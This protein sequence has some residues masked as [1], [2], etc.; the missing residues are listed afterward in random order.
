MIIKYDI[1]L[2]SGILEGVTSTLFDHPRLK[3]VKKP[4]LVGAV[5]LFRYTYKKRYS[6]QL[7]CRVLC[8]TIV[9]PIYVSYLSDI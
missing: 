1:Y 9:W 7:S 5:A 2:F 4:I 6:N 3:F 8:G